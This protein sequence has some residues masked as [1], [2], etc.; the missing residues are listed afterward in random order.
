MRVLEFHGGGKD[1]LN[2]SK[3]FGWGST[4]FCYQTRLQESFKGDE[5][6]CHT[7][8]EDQIREEF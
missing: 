3:P 2:P 4:I 5:R 1:E 7:E 6:R 8:A